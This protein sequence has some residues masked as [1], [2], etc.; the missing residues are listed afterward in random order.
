MTA[1]F[2]ITSPLSALTVAP[3]GFWCTHPGRISIPGTCIQPLRAVAIATWASVLE[4]RQR[5]DKQIP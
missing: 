2:A 1:L 4:E 5:A 3:L